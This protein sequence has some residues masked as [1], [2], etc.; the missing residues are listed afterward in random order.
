MK[1]RTDTENQHTADGFH[2]DAFS[3]SRFLSLAFSGHDAAVEVL[4]EGHVALLLV[5]QHVERVA[6]GVRVEAALDQLELLLLEGARR[7]HDNLRRTHSAIGRSF[8]F[9]LSFSPFSSLSFSFSLS[10]IC[11]YPIEFIWHHDSVVVA[12]NGH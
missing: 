3:S 6:H 2:R 7:L 12:P 10:P 11:F 8:S 9:F 5:V 4:R 1:R